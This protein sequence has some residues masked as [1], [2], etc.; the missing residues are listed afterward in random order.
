MALENKDI[1]GVDYFE[2]V[3]SIKTEDW[4]SRAK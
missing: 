3:G 2:Y 1:I 4:K